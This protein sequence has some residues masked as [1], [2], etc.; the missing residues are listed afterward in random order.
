MQVS[1][2]LGLGRAYVTN[3]KICCPCCF[4]LTLSTRGG[5]EI[6]EVCYWEDDEQDDANADEV[7]GGPNGTL[8]LTKARTTY[9]QQRVCDTLF[10][11]SVRRP[12]NTE[13]TERSPVIVAPPSGPIVQSAFTIKNCN[14]GTPISAINIHCPE[15]A[16]DAWRKRLA[17]IS[18]FE[19]GLPETSDPLNFSHPLFNFANL[20]HAD[21]RDVDFSSQN[22]IV[23][24][25][26]AK[27]DDSNLFLAVLHGIRM[28]GTTL[29]RANLRSVLMTEAELKY[30]RFDQADLSGS[31][32]IGS[33]FTQGSLRDTDLRR[34]IANN[35]DF[36]QTDLSGA[37][38]EFGRF[39]SCCFNGAILTGAKIVGA[40]FNGSTFKGAVLRCLDLT[41]ANFSGAFIEGAFI[42]HEDFADTPVV[43]NIHKSIY[44]AARAQGALDMRTWHTCE[45]T[46]CRAG[47]AVTLAGSASAAL[48]EKIG[49][50]PAA[51]LIYLASDPHLNRIPDFFASDEDA[52]ADM[53]RLA[54]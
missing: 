4:S 38:L 23:D 42:N 20:Q 51:T 47:W 10:S 34:V 13:L 33:R 6:C 50:A 16:T 49:T 37:N 15:T 17:V 9:A 32:L 12:T 25:S 46:H 43:P 31:R 53:K 41:S 14:N 1:V 2:E 30:A 44:A 5:F 7:R 8:S 28:V 11:A 48:E 39:E 40:C 35:A 19:A 21:L 3:S 27:L 29:R 52:M 36:S 18:A 45:T 54:G 24:F 26:H 22:S